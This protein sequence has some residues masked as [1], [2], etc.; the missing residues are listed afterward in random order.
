MAF[1]KIHGSLE[2][3]GN[4]VAAYGTL[5]AVLAGV[6]SFVIKATKPFRD[7]GWG[8]PEAIVGGVIF[9][10]AVSL[11]VSL[12][13]RSWRRFRPLAERPAS[14]NEVAVPADKVGTPTLVIDEISPALFVGRILVETAR[15]EDDLLLV[16]PVI[17]FN[18]SRYDLDLGAVKG[19]I[20]W[21]PWP[22]QGDGDLSSLPRPLVTDGSDAARLPRFRDHIL[23]VEQRVSKSDGERML[24]ALKDKGLNIDLREFKI[25]L[26]CKERPEL[27]LNVPLWGALRVDMTPIVPHVG[28]VIF[29][30]ANLSVGLSASLS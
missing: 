23:R 4:V 3:A 13:L 18:G 17:V 25:G 19:A 28:R 9:A 21:A 2:R 22:S 20:R 11:A 14:E 27:D 15:L 10:C 12:L 24:A 16:I 1:G 5:F 26:L 8:W 29:A 30:S 6:F 7:Q